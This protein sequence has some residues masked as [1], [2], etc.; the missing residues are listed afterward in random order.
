MPECRR[1]HE[2]KQRICFR[3]RRNGTPIQD[4]HLAGGISAGITFN[5]SYAEADACIAAGLDYYLWRTG[6][7]PQEF[8]SEVVVWHTMH[9]LI[10]T[11]VESVVNEKSRK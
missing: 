5:Q 11:H 7:Y 10:K 4:Y 6:Y 9:S 2:Y 1:V 8:K 3:V